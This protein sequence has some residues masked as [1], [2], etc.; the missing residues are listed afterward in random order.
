[1][2][3]N[4]Q[5]FEK[6]QHQQSRVCGRWNVYCPRCGKPSMKTP[7]H[8]NA[9]SRRGDFYVCDSCGSV[10]AIEESANVKIPIEEYFAVVYY[11][12]RKEELTD[13]HK[14][15]FTF[16]TDE[17]CPY[18]GGWVKIIAPDM[19]CAAE[20]FKAL[21]PN[22]RENSSNILNCCS[23]YPEKQFKKSKM[24]LEGNLGYRCHE[25]IIIKREFFDN[26]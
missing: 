11:S 12:K 25:T 4:N 14:F 7:I 8:T 9:L 15:Y 20:V 2:N 22:P 26:L 19:H 1:M 10:E 24:Y 6:I 21:Y 3:N 18:R 5:I 23:I 16:G 17:K 13:N